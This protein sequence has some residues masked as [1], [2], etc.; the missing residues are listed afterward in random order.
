[1]PCPA[2]KVDRNHFNLEQ[3]QDHIRSLL[4]DTWVNREPGLLENGDYTLELLGNSHR[5]NW[6]GKTILVSPYLP[7]ALMKFVEHKAITKIYGY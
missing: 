2:E 1:M 5:L 6:R 4:G 7:I 3:A